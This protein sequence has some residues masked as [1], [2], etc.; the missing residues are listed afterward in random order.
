MIEKLKE[1]FLKH[2]LELA[3]VPALLLIGTTAWVL[4][5]TLLDPLWKRLQAPTLQRLLGLSFLSV[6]VLLAY[7]AFLHHKIRAKLRVGF[8]ILWDKV[9]HPYCPACKSPLTNYAQYHSGGWGFR[10]IKCDAR[11]FLRDENGL[12]LE[13]VKA[14]ALLAE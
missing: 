10:C 8:G 1:L 2:L 7:V 9:L 11:I 4:M 14:K 5:P 13:L 6:V 12:E 3:V